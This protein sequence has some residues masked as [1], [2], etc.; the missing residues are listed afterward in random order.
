MRDGFPAYRSHGVISSASSAS[1]SNIRRR[2]CHFLVIPV[3]RTQSVE[4]TEIMGEPGRSVPFV[5][6]PAQI[7]RVRPE[8]DR[9]FAQ[10]IDSSSFILREHCDR[11]EAEFSD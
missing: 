2:K 8:I 4:G 5:D 9:R 11:F 10:I 1:T 6:L 7:A 3:S